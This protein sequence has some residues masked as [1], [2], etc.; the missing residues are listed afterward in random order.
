GH[1]GETS[2]APGHADGRLFGARGTEAGPR[3]TATNLKTRLPNPHP[4]PL[5]RAGEGT[6]KSRLPSLT[7]ALTRRQGRGF[8]LFSVGL[9]LTGE[10][11]FG[12]LAAASEGLAR[13]R[14]TAQ[15]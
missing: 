15:R 9:C 12:T 6:G 1:G 2:T 8:F 14:G 7:P 10:S 3:P 11:G 5:P 4:D 13:L